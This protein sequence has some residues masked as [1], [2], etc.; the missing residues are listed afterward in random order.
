MAPLRELANKKYT[1]KVVPCDWQI[2]R[3]MDM[4]K[5]GVVNVFFGMFGVKIGRRGRNRGK[6]KEISIDLALDAYG[7]I[8][9]AGACRGDICHVA[10]RGEPKHV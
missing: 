5:V 8:T 2:E 1:D 4:D 6:I 10:R 7:G 9:F 3:P